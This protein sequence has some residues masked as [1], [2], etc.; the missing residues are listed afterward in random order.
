MGPVGMLEARQPETCYGNICAVWGALCMETLA[1]LI[2][3]EH[4]T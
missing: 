3:Q 1:V 2:G 4:Y